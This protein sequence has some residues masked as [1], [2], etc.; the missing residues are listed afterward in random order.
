MTQ[1][2]SILSL[3]NSNLPYKKFPFNTSFLS[4]SLDGTDVNVLNTSSFNNTK[5]LV[6]ARNVTIEMTLNN[7]GYIWA[8]IEKIN[9]IEKNKKNVITAPKSSSYITQSQLLM[10][11]NR[12]NSTAIGVDFK[13]FKTN[14]NA[15]ITFLNLEPGT[16]YGIFYMCSNEGSQG[17]RKFSEVKWL[18]ISTSFEFG[19]RVGVQVL[20][21]IVTFIIIN[22]M[23]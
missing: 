15:N 9:K 4:L 22:S 20:I 10:G 14:N 2:E 19:E 11:F 21:L 5:K 8:I 17:S 13:H 18:S 12:E 3:L 23:I 16:N 1:Q 6:N 7:N